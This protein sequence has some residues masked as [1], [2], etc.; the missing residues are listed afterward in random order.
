MSME[1]KIIQKIFVIDVELVVG[2]YVM[3]GHY[4]HHVI[5]VLKT[6]M[7]DLMTVLMVITM[8]G[9]RFKQYPTCFIKN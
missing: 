7:I 8:N 1:M 9:T 6:F 4:V 3:H 2:L 5:E